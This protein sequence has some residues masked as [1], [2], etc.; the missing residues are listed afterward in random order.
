MEDWP[1]AAVRNADL[2]AR[3]T[4]KVGGTTPLLLE[5]GDPEEL[6]RAVT[7]VRERGFEVRILG[8]GA[9]LI[10][11]DGEVPGPVIATD[12]IR[13]AF[14]YVPFELRMDLGG[15]REEEE[16]DPF[17]EVQPRQHFPESEP[18][19]RLVA[20]A[21]AS[22]PGLVGMSKR[23]GWSGIEGLAGVPGSIGGGVA[24]NAGGSWGDLWDAVER[25]RVIDETGEFKDLLRA[26]CQPSYRNGNLG[27]AIV[28]GVVLEFEPSHPRVVDEEVRRYLLHKRQVQPVTEQSAGCVFKNPDPELSGGR[29]AGQLVDEAGLKGRTRGGA[30]VSEKHG[31]FVVNRGGATAADVLAL[32]EEVRQEVAS[33]FGVELATEV[34]LWGV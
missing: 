22:M 24:M 2:A 14:R 20:W 3:T 1:C 17:V 12:R 8:G 4:L 31:N 9:N 28:A 30:Q 6:R 16:A 32:I 19:P 23:L 10:I 11:A 25:V 34:K 5:P 21:G 7:W 15:S 18:T 13:R 29:S 26:D 27:G 33:R